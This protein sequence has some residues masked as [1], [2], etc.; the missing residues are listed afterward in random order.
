MQN[1]DNKP[2]APIYTW[3]GFVVFW[4]LLVFGAVEFIRWVIWANIFID[5]GLK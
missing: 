4:G 3:V 1:Q 5:A 2:L